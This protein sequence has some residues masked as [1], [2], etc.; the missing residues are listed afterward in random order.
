M[1]RFEEDELHELAA[2][3]ALD[4]VDDLERRAFERH[5]D[6]CAQCRA[7]VASYDDAVSELALSAPPVAPPPAVKDALMAD[8]DAA[9][10][11]AASEH[12]RARSRQALAAAA[13]AAVLLVGG[14][15]AVTQPWKEPTVVATLDEVALVEN[16][17][18]AQ[19]YT[20]ASGSAQVVVT[21]SRSTGRAVMEGDRMKPAPSG[22]S[23]QGWFLDDSGTPRSAGLVSS[24]ESQP[25][26][27]RPGA[28]FA[29]TVEPKGGSKAPT[30]EPIVTVQLGSSS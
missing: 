17:P 28:T 10:S 24:G 25:L 2:P 15:V 4:A 27:G 30:T 20:A 19:R 6:D 26:Q 1:S 11:H 23:Y 5:L 22:H 14:G 9:P 16:A 18:D 3:Y 7:E 29:L 13:A 12:P 21:V 8:L